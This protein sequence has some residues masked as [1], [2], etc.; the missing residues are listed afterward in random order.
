ML[1]W[2]RVPVLFYTAMRSHFS[3]V[4]CNVGARVCHRTKCGAQTPP[5]YNQQ[6]LDLESLDDDIDG[7]EGD[8]R[9]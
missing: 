4:Y 5:H 6:N 3:S 7:P 2:P 8:P 9:V 1:E